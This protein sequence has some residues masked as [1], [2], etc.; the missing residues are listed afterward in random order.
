M[1]SDIGDLKTSQS[2]FVFTKQCNKTGEEFYVLLTN[3]LY[4]ANNVSAS[5]STTSTD[6]V[7]RSFVD[8]YCSNGSTNKCSVNQTRQ[9]ITNYT[10]TKSDSIEFW[11]YCSEHAAHNNETL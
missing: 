3:N 6:N 4:Q 7:V 1:I 8:S 11:F 5:I 9:G 2:K 10:T